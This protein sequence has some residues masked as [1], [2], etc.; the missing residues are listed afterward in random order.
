MKPHSIRCA[1]SLQLCGENAIDFNGQRYEPN[2]DR[3]YFQ[4]SCAG[5]FP[6]ITAHKVAVHPDVVARSYES[7]RH[8]V[9]NFWHSMQVYGDETDRV[10]G[11][12]LDV[13]FPKAPAGG[14]KVAANAADAPLIEGVGVLFKKATS[15]PRILGEHMSGQQR[16]TVS[17]EMDHTEAFN[18]GAVCWL[19]GQREWTRCGIGNED[20]KATPQ[21]LLDAGWCVLPY[22]EGLARLAA[23]KMVDNLTN[24][25]F[26]T[27]EQ[28]CLLAGGLPDNQATVSY[29]GLGMVPRTADPTGEMQRLVAQHPESVWQDPAQALRWLGGMLR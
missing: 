29:C 1:A 7:L 17:Y 13:Q 4:F 24:K 23:C 10:I 21:D 27:E 8:T 5:A 22:V 28:V 20:T 25:P 6:N 14:W 12:V 15:V 26:S 11:S 18:A 19:V 16:W 2:A 3:A 9:I